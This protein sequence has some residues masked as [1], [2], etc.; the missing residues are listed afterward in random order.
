MV[1]ML[2]L[3]LPTMTMPENRT[4]HAVPDYSQVERKDIPDE[5]TWRTE[6]I[7]PSVEEWKKEKARVHEMMEKVEKMAS[8]W[9]SSPGKMLALLEL[10]NKIRLDGERLFYYTFFQ[11]D[12]DMTNHLFQQMKGD[13]QGFYVQ[14]DAR[15]SFMKTDILKLGKETFDRYV[16]TEPGL[17]TYTFP[18]EKILRGKAHV[19][20]PGQEKIYSLSGLFS[21]APQ[22]IFEIINNVEIPKPEVQL[23]DGTKIVVDFANYSRYKE[24]KNRA[25]RALVMKAFLENRK[26]FENTFAALLDAGVKQHLFNARTHKFDDCLEASLYEDNIDPA[27]YHKL[28]Q[29]VRG[30][31]EPLH[32][33]IKLK[34]EMLGLDETRYED[35]YASAVKS[36]DKTYTFEE[37]R[38][39]ILKMMKVLG[40][41]YTTA[42]SKAF[43]GGWIDRYPHK[44]KSSLVYSAD[45]YGVHPYVK[46]NY[47]GTYSDFSTLAHE[48]GHAMHSYLSANEQHFATFQYPPFLAEIAAT[49]NESIL[50]NYLLEHE[51]DDRFKLFILDSYLRQMR[52][53]VYV[54]T[55]LAE[56]ELAIHRRVEAGKTLTAKWLNEK[57][58]ELARFYYG[59]DKGIINVEDYVRLEWS[60][61]PH[62]YYGYYVYTYSTGIIASTAL[63][64]L[65]LKGKKADR[66]RYLTL[67]KAGGSRF[68]MDTLKRA[69]VDMTTEMPYQAAFKRFGHLVSEMER[70]VQQLKK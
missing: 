14:I 70:I 16:Q 60:I 39:I 9:T 49:F 25:T 62:F 4:H 20:P 44:S 53:A 8:D 57:Y 30:N 66:E 41:E 26:K 34:Q 28:I 37:A 61:V 27:V 55:L 18:V 29:L 33:Y 5:Y 40:K 54:Q 69:G 46:L 50:L 36:V 64:D 47:N 1:F 43:T 59:H 67:L 58:L 13:I 31:L 21:N 32:R 7:Y 42:L 11:N 38:R 19:L 52:S 12:T 2:S 24:D 56:F 65:V 68:P 63:S 51:K 45:L 17:K 35:M 3:V 22:K 6:D 10:T 23:P 48:L 15:L